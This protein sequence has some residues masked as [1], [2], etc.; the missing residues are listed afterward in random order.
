[1]PLG[2]RAA[3]L[4]L[5]VGLLLFVPIALAGNAIGSMLRYPDL[6]AAVLFPPY[7]A[8]T[9][10][11]V[12]SRRRDPALHPSRMSARTPASTR[13]AIAIVDDDPSVRTSLSRLCRAFGL[14][15]AVYASGKELLAALD[16]GSASIDCLLLD[17]Y[18][19]EMNGYELW[20]HLLAKGARI[21]TVVF[22]GGDV[23]EGFAGDIAAGGVIYLRK[24]ASAAE[25][26]EAIEQAL[27]G[28]TD[29]ARR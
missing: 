11:L 26:L 9:A 27:R 28:G 4:P 18:M 3:R 6:G 23:P 19:P 10:A 24:P 7:A 16:A 22:T 15:A 20:R 12:A 1:M 25:L 5:A 8:L 14:S 13:R 21:P 2:A 17:M 29:S